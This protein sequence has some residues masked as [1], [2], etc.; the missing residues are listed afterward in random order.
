MLGEQLPTGT[1]G[2]KFHGAVRRGGVV[3]AAVF[4]DPSAADWYWEDADGV[5]HGP[6]DK[7]DDAWA[8]AVRRGA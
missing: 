5:L 4:Y 2:L 3:S 6:L 1:E 7:R 8:S